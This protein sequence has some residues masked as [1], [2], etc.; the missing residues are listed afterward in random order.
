MEH[1]SRRHATLLQNLLP[2]IWCITFLV[3]LVL[4]TVG[5]S[6]PLV[7][8]TVSV[9][10]AKANGLILNGDRTAWERYCT[11]MDKVL[12]DGTGQINIVQVGGSHIQAD[13]W[14]A[15]LRER[16]QSAVPGV[17][18]GR[19][20]IFPYT[21]SKTNNPYWYK[22][23]YTGRWSSVKN[24]QREGTE[25]LGL[26]GYAVTTTDP[27]T[28]LDI[29]FRGDMYPGP[30]F[31]RVKV[32]HGKTD[33]FR[34]SAWSNDTTTQ[35]ETSEMVGYT[36]IQFDRYMDTL[37]L[38]FQQTDST[39]QQFTLKGI[40]LESDDPGFFYHATGVNG[41]S[42]T[43]WLRCPDF[44]KEL[45]LVKPDLVV[46]SI[47][48]NDAHDPDFSADRYLRNY[49]QLI[50]EVVEAAPNAAILLTTNTDS[51]MARKYPNKNGAAVRD[52]MLEL[53]RKHGCVVWDTWN[54]M[55]GKGS[56]AQWGDAGLAKSDLIHF[57]RAGYVT[58]GDLLFSSIMDAYGD[59]IRSTYRP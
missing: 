29:T 49:E 37:H 31:N 17:R 22:P 25:E 21:M 7:L 2:I 19:G 6:N 35:M 53:S 13:M 11:K 30:T 26:A 45:A 43:S 24:L 39:Q 23:E 46:F 42:T 40:I 4:Q 14:S 51:Y 32:L 27:S 10:D 15:E 18:G 52:V 55:G 59:H 58:L 3:L 20:F 44:S 33:Q 48:I 54:V 1:T 34:V 47:G 5:Q 50:S 12:L 9:V 56:I 41:A 57:T 8:P 16:F 38:R 36:E 28:T